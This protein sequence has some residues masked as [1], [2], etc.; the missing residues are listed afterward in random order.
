MVYFAS[1]KYNFD[2]TEKDSKVKKFS[3]QDLDKL[4]SIE[5]D[6]RFKAQARDNDAM[7]P[8]MIDLDREDPYSQQSDSVD[9]AN[10]QDD[11]SFFENQ[12]ESGS[13]ESDLY[14]NAQ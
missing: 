4:P 10:L 2:V 1:P 8:H 6:A 14:I 5:H 3:G 11:S 9:G 12:D 7:N 13:E